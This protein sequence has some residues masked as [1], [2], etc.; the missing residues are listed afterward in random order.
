MTTHN[1]RLTTHVVAVLFVGALAS[2][3][4]SNEGPG[5]PQ[6]RGPGGAGVADGSSLP[7]KWS[8]TDN[9]AWVVE[10]PG[11]GWS[12][13][14][15]WGDRVFVTSAVS[16]G[17]FK[18]PS[19]GIYGN[20]YVAELAKQGLPEAEIVKRV[21]ARDIELT[22]E[23][24]ELS[25]VVIALDARTG[26][27]V[28]Q[29]EAH[30]GAPF[31]GR[32]R[33]NTYASETPATDGERIYASFG[34]NV[35]IFCYSLDGTL[36]WKR[37]WEPQPIYL[38]FGTASSPIVYKGR[39]YQLHD[40]DGQSFLAALDAKTGKEVWT[41]KRTDLAGRIPSGWAT[42]F[43]WESGA[44]TEIVTI[45]RGFVISYDLD[46]REIW[47]LKGMTQATPSPVAAGGL[48]YVGSG[49]QGE[50]NRPL[51]ALRPGASGDVSLNGDETSNSFVTW[52]QP[53]MSGYTPS[54]L[55]YRNRVYV[56]NDN[57]VLQVA[58]AKTGTEV[59]KVRIGGGG[60]TFSS[61]PL[62]S[63]GRVYFLSEDGDTFVLSAGDQYTELAKN[64][65]GEMSL[66]TPAVDA[67]SL[68]VR[69]QTKLYR[70]AATRR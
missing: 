27:V 55:V 43:I 3:P 45:G 30:R 54:P 70:I 6:F 12:S 66:A 18:Q 2:A 61:S 4:V 67:D 32:H 50:A 25:Y 26:K 13:P 56:V 9:V 49:S 65:L 39:V 58:D 44:R 46:G 20:D 22:S 14:I 64:S 52:F 62:A 41:V 24:G 68:Y 19:T 11:R 28:W 29:Q 57:G 31:G 17:A 63:D 8:T 35:G 1:S 23:T 15:V 38:D 69:T 21:V 5:W 33:K 37:S 59:Y 7:D 36:L 48:L 34:G 60:H 42:P 40:N 47:R 10:L 16:P 53:R 51:Y